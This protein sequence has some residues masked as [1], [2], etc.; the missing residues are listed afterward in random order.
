MSEIS[1][2]FQC[3]H[4]WDTPYADCLK[5]GLSFKDEYDAMSFAERS[6]VQFRALVRAANMLP[7]CVEMLRKIHD[8]KTDY[9]IEGQAVTT[10]SMLAAL[11]SECEPTRAGE[12]GGEPLV[13]CDGCCNHVPEKEYCH[14]THS[15]V[16]CNGGGD[17]V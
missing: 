12:G 11:L 7:K 8:E 6:S 1:Q 15:C 10:K 4:K 9:E 14:V 5:C 3:E 2:V 13:M 16:M 17:E